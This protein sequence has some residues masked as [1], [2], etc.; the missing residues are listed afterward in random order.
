MTPFHLRDKIRVLP[1]GD[2][3]VRVTVFVL[4][5]A[6]IVLG[7]AAIVLPGPLTI[8]PVLVGLAI[9]SLEFAFAQALLERAKG[10]ARVAW[11]QAK[12][13]PWR[14]GV[15]TVGGLVL[16]VAGAVLASKHGLVGEAVD[17]AKD[18]LA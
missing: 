17:R 12:A 18:L 16:A 6:F 14:T 8:P 15:V 11:A 4:G 13:H 9:W 5:A 1:G 3:L 2:L 7:A 10:P